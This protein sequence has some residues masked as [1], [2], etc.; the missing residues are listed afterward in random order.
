[1]AGVRLGTA[2]CIILTGISDGIPGMATIHI[3]TADITRI[4]MAIILIGDMADIIRITEVIMEI[5]TDTILITLRDLLTEGAVQ[6]EV[7]GIITA[8]E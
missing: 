8:E 1:M 5:I 6:P 3:G 7:S 4:G 2:E